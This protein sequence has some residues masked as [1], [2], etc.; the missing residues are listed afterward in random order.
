[1]VCRCQSRSSWLVIDWCRAP[2]CCARQAG[3]DDGTPSRLL[4]QTMEEVRQA[5]RAEVGQPNETVQLMLELL[6][7]NVRGWHAHIH[8][9][10]APSHCPPPPCHDARPR[11]CGSR[12]GFPSH[13]QRFVVVWLGNSCRCKW[14]WIPSLER[15]QRRCQGWS[16]PPTRVYCARAVV[17][18]WGMSQATVEAPRGSSSVYCQHRHLSIMYSTRPQPPG[19]MFPAPSSPILHYGP[20][21]QAGVASRVAFR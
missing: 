2:R 20:S 13:G 15:A 18:T 7:E 5:M 8:V 21:W 4:K 14:R 10:W 1:M 11:T 3:G 16:E 12:F 6:F 9:Q 17:S 19:L